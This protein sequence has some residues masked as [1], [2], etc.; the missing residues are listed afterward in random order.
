M[1]LM[2]P[3]ASVASEAG[4]QALHALHLPH[5]DRLLSLLAEAERDRGD[6]FSLSPPHERAFARAIGLAGADGVLPWA[7]LSA[8]DDGVAPND[9]AWG[10]LTPVHWQLGSDGVR[11]LD[12]QLLQ[13]DE[14]ASRALCDAVRELFAREGWSL[15][16]G[17]PLRW[18]A[19]HEWLDAL[20]CASLDRVT[21]RDVDHWLSPHPTAQRVRRL[22]NEVQMLLYTH[23]IND[24]REAR[25]ALSVNS[26]WLSGCGRRQAVSQP[27]DLRIDDR[28]RNP[29]LAADW[30]AWVEA[31]HALDAGPL[32]TALDAVQADVPLRLTF[33]GER[34][35]LEL[36]PDRAP[37]WRRLARRTKTGAGPALLETL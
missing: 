23:P 16:Y 17:A 31:W 1:H 20:P 34:D 15:T 26:F 3:F 6:A 4:Q 21:G 5:L 30:P 28:L 36:Q 35:A 22:Q 11:Q 14:R 33:C 29:A 9:L 12:P 13:L 8:A 19:A 18:Y 37:W 7:A 2:I 10:L 27:A 24:E 25:G 32:R